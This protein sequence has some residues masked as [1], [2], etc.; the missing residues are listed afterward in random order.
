MVR[1]WVA[2]RT[3]PRA[4]AIC[5]FTSIIASGIATGI[6]IALI[7]LRFLSGS[8]LVAMGDA[9]GGIFEAGHGFLAASNWN[10]LIAALTIIVLFFQISFLIGGGARLMKVSHRLKKDQGSAGMN[11]PALLSMNREKWVENTFLLPGDIRLEAQTVGLL[12]PRIV[13]CESLVDTLDTS[14]LKAVIAHEDAH[15]TRRDNLFVALAKS[16]ALTLFYLPGP[17]MALR[18]MRAHME[19][20][21]DRDA[22][23]KAGGSLV[24]AGALARI[25][26]MASSGKEQALTIALSGSGDMTSRMEDLLTEKV[27]PVHTWRIMFFVLTAITT[28]LIF[29]SSALAVV[30]SDQ[31]DALVCFTLHEQSE[32]NGPAC[33]LDHSE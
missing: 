15:R 23:V 10:Y 18:E 24:V 9:C 11:C 6:V 19:K 8:F 33:S 3:T 7:L 28:L 31:R 17:K 14:Q 29:A 12:R 22:A 20:A 25:V 30:G 26:T 1:R 2:A 13:L 5:F 32:E 27:K 4:A 21:A 16:V